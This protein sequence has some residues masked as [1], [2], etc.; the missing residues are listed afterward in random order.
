MQDQVLL[1]QSKFQKI[2]RHWPV[3][4]NELF[5]RGF[6]KKYT[7]T[8]L[9]HGKYGQIQKIY[10]TTLQNNHHSNFNS[11]FS[12]L[13]QKYSTNYYEFNFYKIILN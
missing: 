13:I 11:F 7:P 9:V 10:K 4:H 2:L 6:C 5:A 12:F 3:L 1:E 8:V